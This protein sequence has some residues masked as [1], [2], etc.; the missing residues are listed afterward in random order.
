MRVLIVGSSGIEN[1]IA[2]KLA[3]DNS[4]EMV[5][6]APGNPGIAKFAN[7][8]DINETNVD[9]LVEFAKENLID[10]TIV[11]SKEALEK[12]I[13]NSF[14]RENLTIFGPVLESQNITSK[15][16]Y[17][18]KFCYKNKIPMTKFGVF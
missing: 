10:F 14:K 16:S 15:R 13:V 17:A 2:W 11:S 18:N 1:A 8:I 5:F 12:G 7:C 3:V 4:A 9:E 6:V